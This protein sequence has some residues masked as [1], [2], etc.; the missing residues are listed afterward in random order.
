MACRAAGHLPPGCTTSRRRPRR[1]AA[2]AAAPKRTG[3]RRAVG[4][5]HRTRLASCRSASYGSRP[6]LCGAFMC[7]WPY[8]RARGA[9]A[10]PTPRSPP[11]SCRTGRPTAVSA[12][13]RSEFLVRAD[14]GWTRLWKM[15]WAAVT[16]GWCRLPVGMERAPADAGAS[17]AQRGGRALPEQQAL[18]QSRGLLARVARRARSTLTAVDGWYLDLLRAHDHAGPGWRDAAWPRTAWTPN[19]LLVS[20]PDVDTGYARGYRRRCTPCTQDAKGSELLREA[21]RRA[22]PSRDPRGYDVRC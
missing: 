17:R 10:T 14:A 4:R 7:G 12:R 15:R 8:A 18:R 5:L 2:G 6:G 11:P 1:R 19:P 16:A 22:F 3:A 13:Y 21:P 9:A 20:G